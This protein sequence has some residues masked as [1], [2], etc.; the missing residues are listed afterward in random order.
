MKSSVIPSLLTHITL[1]TALSACTW[2][3]DAD[4]TKELVN[5]DEDGDGVTIAEGDCNDQM[6]NVS[7]LLE[8][9]WYDGIDGDCAGDNDFDKDK[10][11]R[12]R[13]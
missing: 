12:S 13:S 9:V 1:A 11:G 3:S 4:Y 6:P 8:E 7:P 5:V 2:I 10:D